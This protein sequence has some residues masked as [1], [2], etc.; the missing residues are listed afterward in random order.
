MHIGVHIILDLQG[1][2]QKVDDQEQIEI[3]LRQ[4]VDKAGLTPLFIYF[5]Q[6]NPQG[7][8]ATA[9][10]SESHINLHS[11]PEYNYLALDIFTCGN[12]EKAFL[13]EKLLIEYFKP[14]Q[15]KRQVLERH[16]L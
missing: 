11:W 3:T 6:F 2:Q 7:F 13:V 10:L 4:I 9:I 8:T 5:H 12:R 15:V 1:Y 16:S 14:E